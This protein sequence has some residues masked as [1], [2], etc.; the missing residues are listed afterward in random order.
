ME[1]RKLGI[2]LIA[3]GVAVFAWQV[4]GLARDVALLLLGV[5][6]LYAYWQTQ[7]SQ[8]VLVG[9]MLA[10]ALALRRLLNLPGWLLFALFAFIFAAIWLIVDRKHN[11]HGNLV[12]AIMLAVLA[13][14]ATG[15]ADAVVDLAR[16]Q[17]GFAPLLV[18][19]AFAAAYIWSRQLG[20]LIPAT[21]LVAV[22][23]AVSVPD[24]LFEGWM[25]FAALS[26]AFAAVYLIHTRVRGTETGERIWPLFPAG[27]LLAFSI[28]LVASEQFSPH[29]FI[30]AFFG[31][32]AVV[33]LCVY[34]FKRHLG[35][36]IPGLMLG[37][38]AA[39][40]AINAEQIAWLLL[41]LALSFLLIWLVGTRHGQGALQRWWPLVPAA[42]L[43][44]NA[45]LIWVP[46]WHDWLA[47]NVFALA[48]GLIL[49][50]IGILVLLGKNN[51]A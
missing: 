24:H 29:W 27:G 28:A 33:L 2:T 7:R 43:L 8:T 9:S 35:V 44:T 22:G 47:E 10:L 45:C 3:V 26:L 39:W 15:Y 36:L 23:L 20:F 16:W 19:L 31:L 4:Q 13:I 32:P 50:G 21:V 46:R 12:A 42:V 49:I 51:C 11:K 25:L 18:G 1:T 5:L 6:G 40:F 34:C 48:P 38:V 14:V 41:A 17:S 37:S 30:V